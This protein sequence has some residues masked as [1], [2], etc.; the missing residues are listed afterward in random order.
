[1]IQVLTAVAHGDYPKNK[2]KLFLAGGISNCPDWQQEVIKELQDEN[3]VVFN[4]RRPIIIDRKNLKVS[5]EQIAWEHYYLR[6][7]TE[8]LFWF[9]NTSVCPIALF[10]L[11]GCLERN[12]VVYVGCD[13][14]YDRIVDLVIQIEMS[15]RPIK[16]VHSIKDLLKQVK[17]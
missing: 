4:P 15:K 6:E 14:N 11:G 9:P 2:R 1:M 5:R 10:E 7:A 16:L 17:A 8:V 3:I 12:Q 13:V